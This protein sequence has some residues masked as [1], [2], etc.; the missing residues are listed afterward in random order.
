MS[1]ITAVVVT[2]N[3]ENNIRECLEGLR[4]TDEI[5][6]IDSNSPDMTRKIASDF[7]A[8][9]ID[10]HIMYPEEKKNMGIDIATGDWVFIVDADERVSGALSRGILNAVKRSVH[11]GYWVYR[12]NYFLGRL[13]KHCGWG[14]DKVI[15]LFKKNAG[16]YPSKKVHGVLR[17]E[18]TSGIIKERLEHYS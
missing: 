9:V 7:G 5:I 13:I 16:R 2:F 8:K 14:N 15:R 17:L 1:K 6:V 3:E 10:T 11:A 18:G 4:F 12:N